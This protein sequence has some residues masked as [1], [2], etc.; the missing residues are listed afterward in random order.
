M[1]SKTVGPKLTLEFRQEVRGDRHPW[2]FLANNVSDG[3][4]RVL[5]VLTA[6]LQNGGIEPGNTRPRLIGIER[7]E[8]SCHPV[9]SGVL[10]DALLEASEGAQV[11]VTSQ[12]ADLLDRETIPWESILVV[13]SED[14]ETRLG[15]LDET[16]RSMLRDNLFTAGEL[17]RM[18]QLNCAH[19]GNQAIFAGRM[20][21]CQDKPEPAR[22]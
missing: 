13:V 22:P 8:A 12:G 10:A 7:P 3:T 21:P 1:E 17:L 14:G 11:V 18:D 20:P 6:L 16:S 19:D 4:L 9:A 2:R 15:R 5:G